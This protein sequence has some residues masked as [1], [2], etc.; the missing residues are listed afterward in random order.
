MLSMGCA[1][2]RSGAPHFV[3]ASGFPRLRGFAASTRCARLELRDQ[4]ATWS[5]ERLALSRSFL[6]PSSARP[7]ALSARW[8]SDRCCRDPS[9]LPS[10]MPCIFTVSMRACVCAAA[11]S[12]GAPVWVFVR[13]PRQGGSFAR[14]WLYLDLAAPSAGRS[15]SRLWRSPD[16]RFDGPRGCPW[17]GP[18]L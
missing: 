8:L 9:P 7:A 17:A 18:V 11:R 16:R 4:V 1:R 6:E 14:L 3:P 10:S 15:V 12:R 2:S 13:T 5:T